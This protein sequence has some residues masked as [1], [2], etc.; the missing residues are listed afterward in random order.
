MTAKDTNPKTI[1]GQAKPPLGLVPGAAMVHLAEA[2]REGR[3]KYGDANWRKDPVSAS[4]YYSAGL[5]HLVEWWDGEDVDPKSM[6]LHLAHAMANCAILLDA[7]E[8]G[9]LIDDR[10]PPT[11]TAQ[12]IRD[13]TRPPEPKVRL[14]QIG[15]QAALS[16]AATPD[17]R[18]RLD[19]MCGEIRAFVL[20]G[21]R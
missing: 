11:R 19:E 13:M 5:R 4:T 15:G 10:P 1:Y 6:C 12:L 21:D 2:L 18:R 3:E 20:D 7:M 14:E 16:T 9:T 17:F 8:A